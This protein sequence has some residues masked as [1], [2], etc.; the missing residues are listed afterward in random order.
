MTPDRDLERLLDE[1]FGEG[2]SE[3]SDRVFEQ[4]ADRIERQSQRPAWRLRWR[5]PQVNLNLRW[6]AAAAVLVVAIFAGTRLLGP[7]PNSGA[8]VN[9]PTPSPSASPSAAAGPVVVHATGFAVPLTLT[10]VDGWTKDPIQPSNLDLQRGGVDLGF[11]PISMVTLPGDPDALTWIPV[12]A[13]F[14]A[15]I[16]SRPE[17]TVGDPRSV[18]VGGRN[19]TLIDGEFVWKAGTTERDFLR[20]ADGAWRYD[21]FDAGARVR[22]VIVPGPSGDGVIIVMNAADADFDAAAAALDALLATVQFDAPAPSPS[23]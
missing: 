12:P 23:G 7:T 14:V 2:P 21:H 3:V 6:A 13:D 16:R 20:Y 10:L 11:H 9:S 17:F 15:W 18:T 1:W 22:F 5:E 19:G 4:V 8:S